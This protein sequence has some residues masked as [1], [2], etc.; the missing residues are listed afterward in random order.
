MDRNN[1]QPALELFRLLHP[2][3]EEKAA[4]AQCD[5][6]WFGGSQS[7]NAAVVSHSKAVEHLAYLK[8]MNM[9]SSKGD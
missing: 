6:G 2:W 3:L 5:V 8:D 1:L 9:V 7:V 4:K